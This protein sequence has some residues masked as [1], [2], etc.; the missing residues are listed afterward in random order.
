MS[1]T[2]LIYL[3]LPTWREQRKLP[4]PSSQICIFNIALATC[5]TLQCAS[6]KTGL[7]PTYSKRL[8]H[9][10]SS[11][12]EAVSTSFPVALCHPLVCSKNAL[13]EGK[14]APLNRTHAIHHIGFQFSTD[15]ACSQP[16]TASRHLNLGSCNSV[17]MSQK[18]RV[19]FPLWKADDFKIQGADP[20]HKW[21]MISPDSPKTTEGS[22]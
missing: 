10:S 15:R 2:T 22:W 9:W 11:A 14:F 7:D 8:M 3:I 13:V 20:W 19:A 1:I 18:Q 6:W 12:L 4:A 5:A 21:G 16:G 17:Q